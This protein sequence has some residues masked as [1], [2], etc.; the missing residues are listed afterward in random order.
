MVMLRIMLIKRRVT[1]H[2]IH[3][4][5]LLVLERHQSI[6]PE[7]E[8]GLGRAA[9]LIVIQ[10]EIGVRLERMDIEITAVYRCERLRPGSQ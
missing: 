5:A 2:Y 1:Q 6:G 8:L 10:R 9:Y 3:L 7:Q 4:A